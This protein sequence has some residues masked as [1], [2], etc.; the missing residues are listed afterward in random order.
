MSIPVLRLHLDNR[1]TKGDKPLGTKNKFKNHLTRYSF[2]S[3]FRSISCRIV[4]IT[5]VIKFILS[6]EYSYD[7][8]SKVTHD[9]NINIKKRFEHNIC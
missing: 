6:S 7:T 3:Y 9:D 5:D 2:F 8:K 4:R 1:D